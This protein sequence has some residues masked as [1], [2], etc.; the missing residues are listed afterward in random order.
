MNRVALS[1]HRVES[2]VC[3]CVTCANAADNLERKNASVCGTHAGAVHVSP[4]GR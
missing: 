4:S 2:L 1:E 3:V